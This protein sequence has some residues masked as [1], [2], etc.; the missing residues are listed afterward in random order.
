MS[1]SLVIFFLTNDE[2]GNPSSMASTPTFLSAR[3]TGTDAPNAAKALIATKE[4]Q[5]EE[6][7]AGREI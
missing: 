4:E 6:T 7:S 5:Q 2:D 3:S 1:Q